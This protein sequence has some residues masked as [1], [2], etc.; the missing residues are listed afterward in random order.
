MSAAGG[1]GCVWGGGRGGAVRSTVKVFVFV[2]I[3]HFC[4]Y[5][6]YC[7]RPAVGETECKM[8]VCVGV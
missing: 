1:W 8:C 5:H 4:G 2:D 3:L 6:T 7:C